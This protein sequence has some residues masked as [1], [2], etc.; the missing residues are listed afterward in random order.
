MD[1]ERRACFAKGHHPDAQLCRRAD[2][3][4]EIVLAGRRGTHCAAHGR[5][6]TE[7]GGFRRACSHPSAP[8][9][10]QEW[11]KRRAGAVYGNVFAARL[12]GP[13]ILVLDDYHAPSR[14]GRRQLRSQ[15][16]SCRIGLR[17]QFARGGD[18]AGRELR[19]P[20]LYMIAG[21]SPPDLFSA[22]G[23]APS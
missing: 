16:A 8:G 9:I 4:R 1:P 23:R 17:D 7:P 22:G 5:E 15:H 12:E 21:R 10:L 13:A 14:P 11:N 2:A 6:R 20:A 18:R 3:A 19:R